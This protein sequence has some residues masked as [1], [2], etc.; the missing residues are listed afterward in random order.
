MAVVP[1]LLFAAAVA[2]WFL[3]PWSRPEPATLVPP[4]YITLWRGDVG[5]SRA[6]QLKPP[7]PELACTPVGV[8]NS[9]KSVDSV[10][11]RFSTREE[12]EWKDSG[13]GGFGG[14]YGEYRAT[15]ALMPGE[16]TEYV[17]LAAPGVLESVAVGWGERAPTH[18]VATVLPA[19]KTLVISYE[20]DGKVSTRT[21]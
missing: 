2:A 10:L 17:T 7:D 19:G 11:L 8:N 5:E 9:T 16:R 1:V 6:T 4:G 12:S 3:G 13:A 14:T 21:E 18:A 20:P 15:K